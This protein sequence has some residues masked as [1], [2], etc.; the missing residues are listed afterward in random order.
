MNGNS[1]T[2]AGTAGGTLTVIFMN[3]TTADIVKT[4]I[5]AAIGAAVSVLVSYL[6]KMLLKKGKR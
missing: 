2:K 4:I 6:L 3:I 1:L 5:M